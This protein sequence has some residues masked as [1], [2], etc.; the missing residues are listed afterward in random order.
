M[1]QE[2]VDAPFVTLSRGSIS[3]GQEADDDTRISV[4][5]NT[6]WTWS[7]S[8]SWLFSD[9]QS[10][11]EGNEEFTF[12]VQENLSGEDRVGEL[13]F[14]IGGVLQKTL[15]VTQQGS[16]SLSET[17]HANTSV[18]Q[19]RTIKVFVESGVE[20]VWTS[21]DVGWLNG[22]SEALEQTGP[23]DFTYEVKENNT[24][25]Q[26]TAT[27]TFTSKIGGA[28]AQL[29]VTQL[30]G[31]AGG[32]GGGGGNFFLEVSRDLDFTDNGAKTRTVNVTASDGTE[33]G[34]QSSEPSWL[35]ANGSLTRTGTG[36]AE[37]FRYTVAANTTGVSR[38][39]IITFKTLSGGLIAT[40]EVTQF[41]GTGI[42]LEL[43]QEL[44][45]TDS[46][47]KPLS[48]G[49]FAPAGTAWGWS[50][51]QPWLTS[52]NSQVGTSIGDQSFGYSVAENTTADSRTGVIT[53]TTLT[54]GITATLEVT[55]AAGGAT[56]LELGQELEFTDSVAK[57]LSVG[58]FA[59][60]GTA[61]GWSSDQPW[62]TSANSQVGTSIGDQSF[63]YSVAE[64]TTADSRTGV[65][66]FT[67]LTGGI[68][69]T[70]EVTQA[71]G[72]ATYLE[73]GQELEFTDSVAKP[74]SVGVFAPAGTAWG[75]SSDQPWLTS[76]NSQVGTSIGD[77]SFGYSVAENT[78]AD[79]RTGTL[80]FS[81]LSGG[82]TATLTVTQAGAG[83]IY[84]ALDQELEFTDSTDQSLTVDVFASTG[85]AW[86]WTS[87]QPW[88]T[89]TESRNQTGDKS[90]FNYSVTENTTAASRT[91]VITFTT[92]SGGIT[93]TLTVTQAASIFLELDQD[94]DFTDSDADDT[95]TVGVSASAGTEWGWSSNQPWLTTTG[96]TTQTGSQT[97]TY[98]V[99]ANT[100]TESRT[101][102]L[103]F[104]TLSGGLIATLEVT[105]FSG[106]GIFLEL[107]K[108]LD[109]TDSDADSTLK[110]E[111]V[112]STGTD[113]G[114]TSNQP[115]LTSD[116]GSRTGTGIGDE[117]FNYKV[118]ENNTDG[119]RTGIL[120][121]TTLSGDI[122]A[123]LTV[124][125]TGTGAKFLEL[126]QELQF[127]DAAAANSSVKVFASVGTKW[128][129]TS[130]QPWLTS[131]SGSPTGTGTGDETF[132]YKV[133]VN[134][135]AESRT[136]VITFTTLSGGITATLTVTQTGTGAKFLELDQELQFTDAGNKTLSVGVT[137]PAGT[138]WGWISNA[139][140][141]T[142]G[143]ATSQTGTGSV[144]TFNY[145]VAA[146]SAEENRSGIITFTTLSGG[147]IATLEVTQFSGT[148]ENA[149]LSLDQELQFTDSGSKSLSVNVFAAADTRWG[150]ISNASWLT[151]GEATSQNGDHNF[152]YTVRANNTTASRTGTI[153]FSSLSDGITVTLQVTQFSG[154]G[155]GSIFLEL[156]Q[157]LEITNA[158]AKTLKVGL[159]AP[160]D[161]RWGW[162]SSAPWLTSTESRTQNGDQTFSYN[163]AANPDLTA[164]G[165]RSA[166]LEFRTLSGGLIARL[167]V[168]QSR[169]LDTDGDETPN[170]IDEDDDGDGVP[171]VDDAYPLDKD[172]FFV[173][174]D[175]DGVADEDDAFPTDPKEDTDTDKDGIG[176]NADPDDDDDGVLDVDDYDPLDVNRVDS[177]LRTVVIDGQTLFIQR[178]NIV[179]VR[180][181]ISALT[182]DNLITVHIEATISYLEDDQFILDTDW[183]D[184][185]L[186][187]DFVDKLKAALQ[188]VRA[189]EAAQDPEEAATAYMM[190]SD[191]V[192]K[193]LISRTD[194]LQDIGANR[195]ND[196]IITQNAQDIIYVDLIYLS[197]YLWLKML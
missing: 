112:A 154:T 101:G 54:G 183:Q 5:S 12:K 179:D 17:I 155:E 140:W 85:T 74:L 143:E 103:T 164:N 71:A 78:T 144:Q 69:A 27:L 49:V 56:Y 87:N 48:V 22:K 90:D 119:S 58:V 193:E 166:T 163:V 129:W 43:D 141:L 92:L 109:F 81:T 51:N 29:E 114:W 72:G 25:Q 185:S 93:A 139:S 3:V 150:W 24:D 55:Q 75:W 147:L 61:W 170:S 106:T 167:E 188:L 160:A 172:R 41:S 63:G 176:N 20:W 117:T 148:G 134:S 14:F 146:N 57:P 138:K 65:I 88:L 156:D 66:T 118:A 149:I 99:A 11:Q 197:D 16:L 23:Q 82:I 77:Q 125:Q 96:A 110:V 121:F 79:S 142:S 18:T 194:G 1:I 123:T 21:S 159:F 173:D 68:T 162:I 107:D 186:R 102:T 10:P 62:L 127:T 126:D 128:G 30:P 115:W 38:T 169:D 178:K 153:T 184:A 94:L 83:A 8:A 132:N 59:P 98:A 64:N 19:T 46:V 35:S 76:A 15:I 97:V 45:F 100:T 122:T 9:E 151:S 111:V 80:T 40:L 190:A 36:S 192:V 124:T 50:S 39:G 131:D 26:R 158:D 152:N 174:T 116:S 95:L 84:L 31:G 89:S 86:G 133:A 28:T 175:G 113:W 189:A 37:P 91:G 67:T 135:T 73:L 120:T 157:E 137:A 191:I 6:N 53:F 181:G 60:A 182:F 108:N 168:T 32:G 177:G 161:T 7:S 13:R 47:A 44:E 187:Q 52:A 33:W 105:Q 130:N 165:T 171:D 180:R 34:W 195:T 4:G 104:R 2:G 196:W 145:K 42:F 136:G 70:L